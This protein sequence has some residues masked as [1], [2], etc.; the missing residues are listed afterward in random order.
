MSDSTSSSDSSSSG[1]ATVGFGH[2]DFA[3]QP[4]D[5]AS[6][7]GMSFKV[8]GAPWVEQYV[9]ARPIPKRATAAPQPA[10]PATAQPA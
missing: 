8:P 7:D 2:P 4:F 6:A 9:S 1:A 5:G 10:T 3:Y